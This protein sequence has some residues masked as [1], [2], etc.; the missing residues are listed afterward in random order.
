MKFENPIYL[1]KLCESRNHKLAGRQVDNPKL[2]YTHP[3][4]WQACA[5]LATPTSIAANLG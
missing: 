5:T 4:N 3:L 2:F 1:L